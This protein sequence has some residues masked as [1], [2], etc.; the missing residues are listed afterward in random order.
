MGE[1]LFRIEHVSKSFPGTRV[2]DDINI[3]LKKGSVHAIVGENGAGKSTL[4]NVI[5][6][7][8]QDYEGKLFWEGNEVNFKSPIDAQ[9][10]GIAMVHQ[11][12]SLI[13]YLSVM[14]NIYL[15]HYPKKGGIVNKKLLR[16]Q[17]LELM[18]ELK[19]DEISPDDKVVNL[20]VAKKQL[21]EIIKALSLNAQMLMLDEPTAALTTKETKY[22]MDIIDTLRNRGV[23]MIYVS[24]RLEEVFEVAD[25]ISVLRDGCMIVN[26]P[27]EEFDYNEIVYHMVGRKLEDQIA[28]VEDCRNLSESEEVLRVEHLSRRDE[29]EDITF[30]AKKGEILGFGGLVGAG[31]SELLEALFG[32]DP[33]TSG[34]IYLNGEK[35]EIKKPQDAINNGF[36]LVPEERKLKGIFAGLSL[37]DNIN[38]VSYKDL[39]NGSLI[40]KSKE[41]NSAEHWVEQ[42][43]I[44]TTNIKKLVGELSG[45]NQQKVIVARWLR[46]NPTILMMD[47]PT[48]GI[49]VG[50]KEDIY[51]II[52]NL[53]QQGTTVLLVSSEMQELIRLSDRVVVMREG[54][55]QGILEKRDLTQEKIMHLAMGESKLMQ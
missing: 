18:E 3:E 9:N 36:G 54:K 30:S 12:N 34:E 24:H 22:L 31:R 39:K 11:E 8:Y 43:E 6:G 37:K 50:A 10:C 26:V 47:E 46:T 4:M 29:L 25:E 16:E 45:G 52:Q 28:L 14:D 40:N 23:A 27:K 33:Y 19:I 15:G 5:Y 49:D 17:T 21:V 38:V 51:G 53:A 44:R 35:T 42:L 13:P 32:F 41:N 55:M 20:S 2:L 1:T 7:V 48:H